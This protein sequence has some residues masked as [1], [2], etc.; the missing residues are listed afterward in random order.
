L[1]QFLIPYHLVFLIIFAGMKRFITT[2]IFSVAFILVFGQNNDSDT[3][4]HPIVAH[5]LYYDYSGQYLTPV[6]TSLLHFEVYNPAFTNFALNQYIGNYGSAVLPIIA[7]DN[8]GGY[9]L[10]FNK[11]IN[12]NF[13][14]PEKVLYYTTRSPFSRM[15]YFTGGPKS[16]QEQDFQFT[17]TQN[18]N[19]NLNIGILGRL[20]YS[21]GEYANQKN[22]GNSF[23]LFSSYIGQRY[24]Y[25]FN[26]NLNTLKSTENGGLFSDSI[27]EKINVRS[28]TMP[29]RLQAASSISKNLT[30][31]FQHRYYLTGS[32]KV[33]STKDDSTK[34]VS[35]WNEVL[36]IIHRVKYEKSS[37]SFNDKLTATGNGLLDRN[38]YH[39][40][41]IDSALTKDSVLFRQLENNFLLAINAMPVLKIPAELRFGIKNQLDRVSYNTRIDSSSTDGTLRIRDSKNYINSALTGSLANRFSKTITWGASV[42]LYFTGYK[43]GNIYLSGD[44]SKTIKNNFQ[45]TLK[46][47][48][49]IEKAPYFIND[50]ESN[51]FVWHYSNLSKQSN[52]VVKAILSHSKLKLKLEGE[53]G[54]Y[55]N[56]YYF[57]F[58]TTPEVADNPFTMFR[59]T[60]T[61][62]MDWKALHTM[63]R[64]TVQQT[65]NDVAMPMPLFSGFNSSYLEF[66]VFKRVLQFQVGYDVFYNS[67]YY[68]KAYMPAT[69]L[70]Y[71]Q[72]ELKSKSTPYVDV[73]LNIKIKR[74]QLSLKYENITSFTT[75]PA[76]YFTPHYP[77]NPGIL[78]V[79][80]SWNFYD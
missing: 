28:Y 53:S 65:T 47:D 36:S 71:S 3:I 51:H 52:T 13:Y 31:F 17:H 21:D 23:S 45:M 56:F 39:N 7:Q 50:F 70:F 48:F 32:Y 22:K 25:Y 76:G 37:R 11:Y 5:K 54:S 66:F 40:I 2:F 74:A 69:G 75:L 9:D 19:K 10:I 43:A 15:K 34:T 16:R 42:D 18:V 79:G 4:K 30:I 8:A 49:C 57:G 80:L 72:R 33:D 61:K 29:V 38:Y 77:Y 68:Y 55:I 62:Y 12:Y 24:N 6:D 20:I 27:Y 41:Y 60:G 1:D 59:V 58:D 73:F 64:V 26:A 44:I 46:G 63:F 67:P 35:K 14:S 78:K